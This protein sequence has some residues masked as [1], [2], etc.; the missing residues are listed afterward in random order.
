MWVRRYN[1]LLLTDLGEIPFNRLSSYTKNYKLDSLYEIASSINKFLE[2]PVLTTLSVIQ[3]DSNSVSAGIYVTVFFGIIA[4]LIIGGGTIRDCSFDKKDNLMI[5]ISYRWFSAF[6]KDII[7]Y[8]LNDVQDMSIE[9][10]EADESGSLYRI[11]FVLNSGKIIP[12]TNLYSSSYEEKRQ[13]RDYIKKFIK[14]D[15]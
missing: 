8:S 7:Q 12:L 10:V 9:W 1:L 14:S 3:D 13:L 15:N 6:G 2:K 5:L 11:S 4:L